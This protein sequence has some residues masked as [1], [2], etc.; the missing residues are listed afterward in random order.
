MDAAV[1]VEARPLQPPYDANAALV[2]SH[3][4]SDHLA[5]PSSAAQVGAWSSSS[6]SSQAPEANGCFVPVAADATRASTATAPPHAVR[7][8]SQL[9]CYSHANMAS[10][11][12]RSYSLP[13][14]T[15]QEFDNRLQLAKQRESSHP[16]LNF[17]QPAHMATQTQ[18]HDQLPA[19]LIECYWM[20]AW[21]VGGCNMAVAGADSDVPWCFDES[22]GTSHTEPMNSQRRKHKSWIPPTCT[23]V[24]P[25][26][27]ARAC[28]TPPPSSTASTTHDVSWD[29]H[30]SSNEDDMHGH[31]QHLPQ[32]MNSPKTSLHARSL[33]AATKQA[34]LPRIVPTS[35]MTMSQAGIFTSL[36]DMV[37]Q[38]PFYIHPKHVEPFSPP[39]C[40]ES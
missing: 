22:S 35:E 7:D 27:R 30:S 19:E 1:A 25:V 34:Y 8:G 9:G 38:Q 33:A 24:D 16:S 32:S 28:F 13:V 5:P 36:G 17:E 20:Q 4:P 15:Q 23:A 6:S 14:A 39:L 29:M 37:C 10:L 12:K 26:A 18:P 11:M 21:P 2:S 31:N 40:D 3:S